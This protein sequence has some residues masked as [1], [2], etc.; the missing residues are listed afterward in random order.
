MTALMSIGEFA[1]ATGL[2]V[3]ALRFYDDRAL[4]APVDVDPH[5]GYRRYAPSQVRAAVQIRVLRAA[6]L[7]V[8]DAPGGAL[9]H[10]SMIALM[11]AFD[12]DAFADAELRQIMA[13]PMEGRIE[14]A[15]TVREL[16]G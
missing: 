7:A 13:D 11:E 8:E 3:K 9:P 10:P 4:L 1:L 6:G 5:S 15:A 16:E 14:L 12:D 2:S